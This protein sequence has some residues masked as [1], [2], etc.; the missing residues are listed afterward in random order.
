[1]LAADFS[2]HIL[3]G[4]PIGFRCF[5]G[6]DEQ[7]PPG[8]SANTFDLMHLIY[9]SRFS[10]IIGLLDLG[11]NYPSGQALYQVSVRYIKSLPSASFRSHFTVDTLAFGYRIP[12]ITA[13]AGLSPCGTD[14]CPAHPK[15]HL[16]EVLT[17][18][19]WI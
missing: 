15:Y 4:Y 13:P 8:V 10:M 19:F 14:T 2:V 5:I 12:I 3:M 1:M 18:A 9:S 11:I 16:Y 7:R 17:E 6:T